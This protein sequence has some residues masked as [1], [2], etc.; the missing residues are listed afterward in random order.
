MTL[1]IEAIEARALMAYDKDNWQMRSIDIPALIA[2]VR[3]LEEALA[4]CEETGKRAVQ[5]WHDA[6]LAERERCVGIVDHVI[7]R[8]FTL[9]PGINSWIQHACNIIREAI[10]SRQEPDNADTSRQ[11]HSL[12]EKE[13]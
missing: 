7:A 3:E 10:E 11:E 13:R 2:R 6:A 5:G 12:P 4:L 9:A 8:R 1:D